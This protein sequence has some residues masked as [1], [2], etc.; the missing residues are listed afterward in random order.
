M[1]IINKGYL[2]YFYE[3]KNEY[4]YQVHNGVYLSFDKATLEYKDIVLYY[5]PFDFKSYQ[6]ASDDT[7]NRLISKGILE[8]RD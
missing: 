3:T 6:K 5:L 2:D 7:I 8:I 1:I 4:L